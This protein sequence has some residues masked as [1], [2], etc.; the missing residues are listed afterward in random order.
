M[1]KQWRQQIKYVLS[2]YCLLNIGWLLYTVIR[3]TVLP[4]Y[5]TDHYSF[6]DH[7]LSAPV[8][9]GQFLFP[10][11]MI[12]LYWL[13]GYY[14]SAFFK[15]RLEEVVNTCY[16]SFIGTIIIFFTALIN[17]D[18]PERM[19]NYEMLISLWCLL[20]I[21]VYIGRMI[22]TN[23]ANKKVR[24]GEI[25]FNTLI[26]GDSTRAKAIAKKV[27]KQRLGNGFNVVGIVETN[28][29]DK[30]LTLSDIDKV[31]KLIADND[32]TR[33]IIASNKAINSKIGEL[34]NNLFR[35][36]C[37]I[38]VTPDLYNIIVSRPRI[39]NVVG[40]PLIDISNAGTSARTLNCK[41]LG[42]IVISA[43]ALIILSPVFLAIA[44]AVKRDSA[45][46]VIYSQER[47]GRHQK[48]FNIYKFR[49]MRAD[50]EP[51]GPSLSKDNDV[52]VTRVGKFLRKYRLDELPQFY[53]VLRG[54]MSLVGPRPER[55]YYIRQIVEKAP[56]YNLLHQIRPGITSWG[57]VKYGYASTVDQMVERL[58]Y[59][60]I[61][62]DNVSLL[63]DLKI[64][65]H[66][67]NT[68]LTGKGL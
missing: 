56:Y 19:Q 28:T 32:V 12:F 47:I 50:A 29:H 52:R 16:V 59:D 67:V 2:D 8:L 15:S 13:S 20:C 68:V 11:M 44:V 17:D 43:F 31:A 63:V 42:D 1:M 35:F 33:L 24:L 39:T 64:L 7:I 46:S 22:I 18:I 41:R 66:T 36:N 21:P 65:F 30:V 25:A 61:Y 53:N 45:G 37:S 57:M 9:L 3:Y 23:I 38:F 14:N 10:V 6:T 55:E 4:E 51:N 60:L 34:I 62:L 27:G 54:D 49:T 26:I 58:Q 5:F 48:P 40:E